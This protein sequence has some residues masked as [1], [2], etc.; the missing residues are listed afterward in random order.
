MKLLISCSVRSQS[1]RP[2][3]IPQPKAEIQAGGTESLTAPL[4]PVGPCTSPK[5]L[6]D[7]RSD[8]GGVGEGVSHCLPLSL[9]SSQAAAPPPRLPPSLCQQE[10]HNYN[11]LLG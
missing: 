7:E 9:F 2:H 5:L 8:D 10:L 3:A 4:Y 11:A 6:T 1:R